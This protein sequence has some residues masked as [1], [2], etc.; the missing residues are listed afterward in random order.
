MRV[1]VT[2]ASGMLGATLVERWKERYEVYATDRTNFDP[3]TDQNFL[4]FDLKK[5]SY[6]DLMNWARPDV[7]IHCGA[8]TNVD[9]CENHEAEALLINGQSVEKLLEAVLCSSNFQMSLIVYDTLAAR[10]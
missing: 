6:E 10:R 8:L 9:Y 2:G 5:E 1:L 3:K 7:V 4:C